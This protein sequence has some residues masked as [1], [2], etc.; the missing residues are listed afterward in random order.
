[1]PR[2][3]TYTE[4]IAQ[5]RKLVQVERARAVAVERVKRER[6]VKLRGLNPDTRQKHAV[7]RC[8]QRRGGGGNAEHAMTVKTRVRCQAVY[9]G[10]GN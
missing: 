9:G 3:P 8:L 6:N 10:L 2:K 4:R 1:M 7:M 5:Q